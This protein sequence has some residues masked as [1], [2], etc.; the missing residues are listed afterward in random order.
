LDSA[1]RLD[2]RQA[3]MAR[4]FEED[5]NYEILISLAVIDGI[6]GPA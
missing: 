5:I 6:A 2:W 1:L 4:S 3:G